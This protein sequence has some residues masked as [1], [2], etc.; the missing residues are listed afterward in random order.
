VKVSFTIFGEPASKA[1]SRKIVTIK[2]RPAS[3]KSD[4]ARDYVANALKQ[5]PPA[6]RVSM[7][8]PVSLTAHIFYASQRPDLDESVILDVL[9]DQHTYVPGVDGKK[10]RVL[11]QRGVYQNDRQVREK[12]IY[13]AI[14]KANPRA[15]IEVQQIGSDQ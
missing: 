7:D 10:S 15:V 9:Q 11:T 5:I 4:K 12:H 3:I 2:G 6:A 1:N 14:D 8:G 13:H